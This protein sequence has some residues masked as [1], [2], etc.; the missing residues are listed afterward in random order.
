M[1]YYGTDVDYIHLKFGDMRKAYNFTESFKNRYPNFCKEYI[2]YWN[3]DTTCRFKHPLEIA[4][5]IDMFEIP[6]HL[7]F[8]FTDTPVKHMTEVYEYFLREYGGITDD[9][10]GQ[11]RKDYRLSL[12]GDEPTSHKYKV[13][14][15]KQDD[16]NN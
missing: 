4:Q 2:K 16:N 7:Y 1:D 6:V 14:E 3:C 13:T 8:N 9:E 15:V 10:N 12:D 5:Y 11:L